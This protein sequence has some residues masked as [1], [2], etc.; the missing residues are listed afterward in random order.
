MVKSYDE[1]DDEE[2][3]QAD[4]DLYKVTVQHSVG[5]KIDRGVEKVIITKED[6]EKLEKAISKAIKK[7]MYDWWAD[8]KGGKGFDIIKELL[9]ELGFKEVEILDKIV[10]A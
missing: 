10:K 5:K 1:L 3:E 2:R 6:A 7:E 8:K 9:L 4:I